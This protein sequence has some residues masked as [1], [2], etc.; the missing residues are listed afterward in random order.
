MARMHKA[1]LQ[2]PENGSF[3]RM[4]LPAI[5]GAWTVKVVETAPEPGFILCGLKLQLPPAGNPE[6]ARARDCLNP[7]FGV[8]VIVKL[9]ED[10]CPTVREELLID[11]E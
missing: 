5:A 7:F 2:D 9:P 3:R 10:P 4:A 11:N 8:A 1:A 6:Q